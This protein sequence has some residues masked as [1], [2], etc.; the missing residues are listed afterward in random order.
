[1]IDTLKSVLIEILEKE[2]VDYDTA[3]ELIKKIKQL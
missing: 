3:Q 2:R 1:V